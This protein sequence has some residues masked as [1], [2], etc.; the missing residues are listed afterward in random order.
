MNILKIVS[1]KTF[2]EELV[3]C[4]SLFL[5]LGFILTLPGN[6]FVTMAAAGSGIQIFNGEIFPWS[7]T[8]STRPKPWNLNDKVDE[9]LIHDE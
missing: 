6:Y 2:I 7:I 1:N 9:L 5:S 3:E 4:Y 8:R